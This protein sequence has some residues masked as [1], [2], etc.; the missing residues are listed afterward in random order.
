MR[1]GLE[2]WAKRGMEPDED[3]DYAGSSDRK[4]QS[5]NLL[6]LIR[7]SSQRAIGAL[8]VGVGALLSGAVIILIGQNFEFLPNRVMLL[9]TIIPIIAYFSAVSIFLIREGKAARESLRSHWQRHIP[10]YS[11]DIGTDYLSG[12]SKVD[13]YLVSDRGRL[14]VPEINRQVGWLIVL[15]NTIWGTATLLIIGLVMIEFLDG[16][17]EPLQREI[18]ANGQ[19]SVFGALISVFLGPVIGTISIGAMT[20]ANQWEG[21]VLFLAILGLPSVHIAPAVRCLITLSERWHE[22]FLRSRSVWLEIPLRLLLTGL[23]GV[24]T[25]WFLLNIHTF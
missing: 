13:T 24:T 18:R 9:F 12:L 4:R 6:V 1:K 22:L 14:S 19:I 5:D 23:Y 2:Y 10:P 3:E 20:F 8:S 7:N 15:R 16:G 25:F 11:V 21:V 17:I